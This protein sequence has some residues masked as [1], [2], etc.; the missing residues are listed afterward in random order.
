MTKYWDTARI[1]EGRIALNSPIDLIRDVQR[2][3]RRL[4]V[5]F[6]VGE[7]EEQEGNDG[8]GHVSNILR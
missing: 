4:T 8:C 5:I 6:K 2:C 1:Q 7:E 3:E